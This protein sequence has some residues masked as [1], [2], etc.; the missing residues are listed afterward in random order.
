M[1]EL[2]VMGSIP[3]LALIGVLTLSHVEDVVLAHDDD[4]EDPSGAQ[5][6]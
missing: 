1:I 6:A 5:L 2:V 4:A 3:I